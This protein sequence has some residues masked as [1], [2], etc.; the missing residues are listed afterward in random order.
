[1]AF[2]IPKIKTFCCC[3][4]LQTGSYVIAVLN[5]MA[6]F[7]TLSLCIRA[8]YSMRIH[9]MMSY[10][11]VFINIGAF[12]FHFLYGLTK[13]DPTLI[14]P[15]ILQMGVFTAFVLN[16][17]LCNIIYLGLMDYRI[18]SMAVELLG[19]VITCYCLLYQIETFVL[20]IKTSDFLLRC[21]HGLGQQRG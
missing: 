11:T 9:Q 10:Y 1:M 13:A 6:F 7:L 8:G 3:T 19:L 18:D 5:M 17:V 4:S 12:T 20:T 21:R 15:W 16:M 14:F 2:R